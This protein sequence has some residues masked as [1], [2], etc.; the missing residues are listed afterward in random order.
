MSVSDDGSPGPSR[1]LDTLTLYPIYSPR[2]S[3]LCAYIIVF[4]HIRISILYIRPDWGVWENVLILKVM[5][6]AWTVRLMSGPF[7]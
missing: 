1:Y 4:V 3:F 5:Y 6:K 2:V 7:S